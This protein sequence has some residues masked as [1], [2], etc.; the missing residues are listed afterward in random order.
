MNSLK[1]KR[2]NKINRHHKI[3]KIVNGTAEKP[4]MS[5]YKSNKNIYVQLIDDQTSKTIIGLSTKSMKLKQGANIEAAKK[6]GIEI[7]KKAKEKKINNVVF[8]RGGN[9]YHGVIK[10]V[11]ESARE[12][13]LKI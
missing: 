5:V 4:R 10:Q 6:I 9:L 2:I 8:D 7:A 3:R 13:G 11:A 12:A 1:K